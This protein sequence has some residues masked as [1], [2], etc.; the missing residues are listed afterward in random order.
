MSLNEKKRDKQLPD[1]YIT[2]G[3]CRSKSF[4]G[5]SHRRA[6]S[7]DVTF[8]SSD[9]NF[10]SLSSSTLQNGLGMSLVFFLFLM[11][12]CYIVERYILVYLMV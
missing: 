2:E 3:I 8:S 12:S 4:A 10:E 6:S 5:L 11:C 1:I 7:A 9:L